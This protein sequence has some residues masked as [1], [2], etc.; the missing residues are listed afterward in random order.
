M[1]LATSDNLKYIT[2]FKD[3]HGKRRFYFRYHHQ[4]FKL[5]EKPGDAAFHDS[6]A[7]YLTAVESGALGRDDNL[8]YLNGSIGWVIERFLTSDVGF[9][10]LKPGTQRN[11][12]RWLDTIKGDVGRF[13]IKDLSPVAV[14]AMRDSI[15]VKSAATTADMCVMVVS[16]LWKFA[17]EFCHLPLGHNPAHGVARVHTEKTSR[18]PWPDH[19]VDKALAKDLAAGALLAALYGTTRG[20]CHPDEMGRHS[21]R[22][23]YGCAGKNRHQGLD[24]L[25]P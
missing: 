21:Q 12:R 10:K 13:Q 5:P 4:K 11:Y 15:K 6:Y 24:T 7:R 25:A 22:R 23:N 3:R 19:V 8:A 17:I 1:A 16:V 20:R 2:S 9:K 14:R 18:Q